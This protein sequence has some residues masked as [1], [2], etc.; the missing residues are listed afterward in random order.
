MKV[1]KII[2]LL[3]VILTLSSFR[4]DNPA[5]QLF[6]NKGK[7]VKYKKLLKEAEKADIVFF[8]ELH[9]NPI[10]HWLQLELTQDL[11]KLKNG[12]ITMGAEMFEADNQVILDEYLQGIKDKSTFEEEARLWK[13][14]KTDIAPLVEFAKENKLRFVASNIPRR[15]ASMVFRG[16]FEALDTLS[17]ETKAFIAPLPPAYDPELPGYKNM[18]EMMA[19]H[20]GKPN[21]NFPKAQAIKDATMAY[22]IH[23]NM[24]EGKLF[25]HYHGTYHSDNYEGILWYLKLLRPDLKMLTIA[26]TEAEKKQKAD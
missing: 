17:S 26:T 1:R 4:Q 11:F 15:Y 5:Y 6:N 24:E 8:G 12:M 25:I 23:K 16:G 20:G 13:N 21:E 2:I 9:N 10:S 22:F 14:Y 19:G 7:Q 18:M 3:F